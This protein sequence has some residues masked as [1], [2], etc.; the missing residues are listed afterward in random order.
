MRVPSVWDEASAPEASAKVWASLSWDPSRTEAS[1]FPLVFSF[2]V[3]P[4][5]EAHPVAE[6]VHTATQRAAGSNVVGRTRVRR[7]WAQSDRA[8]SDRIQS[9]RIQSDRIQRDRIQSDRIQRGCRGGCAGGFVVVF[10]SLCMISPLLVVILVGLYANPPFQVGG[11]S[12]S[13]SSLWG[14]FF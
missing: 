1:R 5:L 6:A 10:L 2:L 7:A 13:T 11:V 8:Q 12:T 4:V 14:R 9:D 3:P